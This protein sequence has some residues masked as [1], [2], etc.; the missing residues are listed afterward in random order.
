MRIYL[1]MVHLNIVLGLLFKRFPIGTPVKFFKSLLQSCIP[2]TW[3]AFGIIIII[4]IIII[5]LLLLN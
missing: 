4:I 2:A 1:F 3:A 5:I